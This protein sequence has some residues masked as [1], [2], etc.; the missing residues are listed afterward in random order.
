MTG[1]EYF[2]IRGGLHPEDL[3]RNTGSDI[4]MV[5]EA[6]QNCRFVV[7]PLSK[8]VPGHVLHFANLYAHQNPRSELENLHFVQKCKFGMTGRE[9]GTVISRSPLAR[10]STWVVAY[11]VQSDV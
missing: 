7:S 6:L 4:G 1:I 2:L 10:V 8:V 11:N 9:P 5:P 3:F